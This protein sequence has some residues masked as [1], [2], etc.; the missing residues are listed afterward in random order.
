MTEAED[1]MEQITIKNKQEKQRPAE[2]IISK[3]IR[4]YKMS[5]KISI[6]ITALVLFGFGFLLLGGG[7]PLPQENLLPKHSR[8]SDNTISGVEKAVDPRDRWTSE[9]RREMDQFK[10]ELKNIMQEQ[11][12]SQQEEIRTIK[13]KIESIDKIQAD[14]L[15][16]P[17]TES[18]EDQLTNILEGQ[19]ELRGNESV[20]GQQNYNMPVA[21]VNQNRNIGHISLEEDEEDEKNVEEYVTS[22]SFARAVLMTGVVVGTGTNS[23]SS[24]E[25]IMLRLVDKG[26]FS[27]EYNTK[28]LKEAILIGSCSGDISSERARCRLET[29]SLV[30]RDGK[31]IERSVEGWLIGEDGRPG[32]RGVIVDR[33]SDVARMAVVNGVLG[34]MAQFFQNQATNSVFP[35]SPITGQQYALKGSKALQGGAYAGAGNALEKLADF[36]IKRAEGMSPVIMISSGRVVDVVFRKGFSLKKDVAVV[37][38]IGINP[39]TQTDYSNP[40][41]VTQKAARPA[42]VTNRNVTNYKA[43][44]EFKRILNEST[45]AIDQVDNL[46]KN[47]HNNNHAANSREA[48]F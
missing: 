29:L 24:P 17:A 40:A 34:G 36:A 14:I 35:I 48:E 25:P 23:A 13:E 41:Q 18:P 33:S 19:M 6:A 8:N 45:S 12:V 5:P 22:G 9:L 47:N 10:T 39:P 20:Q 26:I 28:Q 27:K 2:T 30:N 7:K 43:N 37:K 21:P 4:A 42:N 11:T 31:I 38:N 46:T 3:A 16:P 1:E 44:N 32:V 15:M